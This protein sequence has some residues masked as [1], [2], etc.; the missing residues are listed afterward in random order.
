M[1]SVVRVETPAH[2]AAMT[3][4]RMAVFVDEQGVDADVEMDEHDDDPTTVHVLALAADGSPIGTARLL[5]PHPADAP[6]HIGRVAVLAT[7][8]GLGIGALLMTD[9]E[10]RALARHGALVD[11]ARTVSVELSAQEGALGF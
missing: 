5:A 1:T 7:A 4:I 6:A 3:A 2:R 10:E 9:L 11:G 8:R